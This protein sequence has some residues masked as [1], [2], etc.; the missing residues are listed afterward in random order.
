MVTIDA[1]VHA[2]RQ[3]NPVGPSPLLSREWEA[4]VERLLARMDASGVDRAVL[5]PVTPHPE[6]D[7][8]VSDAVK[9][10]P[11]RFA[12]IG[13]H[14]PSAPDPATHYA[15]RADRYE[16]QGLRLYDLKGSADT[17]VEELALFPLLAELERL[18]HNLWLYGKADQI[19]L[20]R[21][22]LD[23]LPALR[24]GLNLLGYPSIDVRTDEHGRPHRKHAGNPPVTLPGV[25][26]LADYPNVYVML[27]GLYQFSQE[28]HP[29]TDLTGVVRALFERFGAERCFWATDWPW[30]DAIPGYAAMS[31]IVDA[32]LPDLSPDERAAIFGGT[33]ARLFRFS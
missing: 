32:N 23:E 15:R 12:A 13:V 2:H 21:K 11:G 29:H 31:E 30:I 20:L 10:H 7:E 18:Q 33:A 28:P 17:P 3:G 14:D 27:G 4:P 22:L 8:Y 24:V 6:N 1:H 19:S 5:V 16:L 25:L 9:A 26:D